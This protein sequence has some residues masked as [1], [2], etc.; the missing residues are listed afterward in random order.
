M[1]ILHLCLANFYMDGYN[2]QENVLPRINKED[3]HEVRIIASTVSYTDNLDVGFVKPSEYLTEYGVPIK[4]I[5]YVRIGPDI[6]TWRIRVYR[7]LY[8]E[9]ADFAPDVIFAHALSFWSV[10]D[11]IRYKKDHP[12]VKFYADTHTADY[13]SGRTWFTMHLLHR[14]LYR[15]LIQKAVPYLDRFFY[16]GSS[17][18]DF[19]VKHYGIPLEL[20]EFYPLG[21]D[22]LP[23]EEYLQRRMVRRAELDMAP[24]ELLLLHS[25]KLTATK[26]TK[27]LLEAFSA[28]PQ[29]KAK[30]VIIGSIPEEEN[31]NLRPLMEADSRVKYLGWKQASELLEYLCACDLYCQPGYVSATM[32][33]AVCCNCP[34]MAYPHISYTEALDYGN[35]LWVKTREDMVDTFQNL[36]VGKIDLSVLRKGSERCAGELLDYRVLAA[37][38]YQ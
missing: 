16:I 22:L 24:G 20:M 31:Q 18:R 10:K 21:G 6:L 3:G 38:I 23:E 9:I 32:Q 7:N 27:E 4:R 14:G 17:E 11:V 13:N 37:R 2:Y 19:A 5:P 1:R 30:L 25:G 33:N 34:I 26:R 8:R 12:E 15:W 35:I 36:A 29:L 28:V